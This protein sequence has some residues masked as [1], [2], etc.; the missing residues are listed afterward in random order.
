MAEYE[1][2]SVNISINAETKEA[3]S[4]LNR[5]KKNLNSFSKIKGVDT[6]MLQAYTKAEEKFGHTSFDK[7]AESYGMKFKPL[8]EIR[9]ESVAS[10]SA[11]DKLKKT[12]SGLGISLDKTSKKEGIFLRSLKF[13]LIY[14]TIYSG[15]RAIT[16][17]FKTG[18]ENLYQYSKA[19]NGDFANAMDSMA[20]S[21][22]YFH[23]SVGAAISPLAE[24]FAPVLKSLVD[25]VVEFS[26]Q[27]NQVNAILSGN[28]TWTKAVRVEKEYAEAT[29]DAAEATKNLLAGF[30]ELN[31]IQSLAS[32]SAANTPDYSTMFEEVAV[33]RGDL[34]GWANGIVTGIEKA[35][36]FLGN[37]GIDF[38][39]IYGLALKVGG[40]LLAWKLGSGLLSGVSS[41]IS[42]LSKPIGLV[43][44]VGSLKILTDSLN[45]ILYG[46]ADWRDYVKAAASVALGGI[47]LS[48]LT[49]KGLTFGMGLS[50]AVTSGYLL[51]NGLKMQFDNS[52][53]NDLKG[54]VV[55]AIGAAL[56]GVAIGLL[57]GKGLSLGLP[58]ALTLTSASLLFS[59]I[60]GL[61][62]GASTNDL[63]SAL[64]VAIGGALGGASMLFKAGKG[65]LG[66]TTAIGFSI[67]SATLLFGGIKGLFDESTKNDFISALESSL[68][69]ALGGAAIANIATKAGIPQFS[70]G[71]GLD[72]AS[73][74]ILFTGT[75]LQTAANT[76]KDKLLALI[77]QG[78]G[79]AGGAIRLIG[80]PAGLIASIPLT[81]S[82]NLTM[83][84]IDNGGLSKI[85]SAISDAKKAMTMK[86]GSISEF[87]DSYLGGFTAFFDKLTKKSNLPRLAGYATGGFPT[88]GEIFMAR[89][90]GMTEYV[91]SMGNRA[92][93]ANNDQIVEGIA[94]GVASANSE[95]NA[96]LREQNT[97]LRQLLEKETN[98]TISPSAQLGRVNAKSAQMYKAMTGGY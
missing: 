83:D 89:E 26:N 60:K 14:T 77:L 30:D 54:A 34:S 65:G 69:F 35:R 59:G 24:V 46:D 63:V 41:L 95:Q 29:T 56:G 78:V 23:N 42:S 85:K 87:F 8:S 44:T 10:E 55:S 57:S 97:L 20:T 5:L 49:G 84:F 80:G 50:L 67:A 6:S 98:V 38:Q 74:G 22:Q 90:N 71:L 27:L 7:F 64:E 4:S 79:F 82:F 62:D 72:F 36:E 48:M 3:E 31:V 21:I 40:A 58:L 73:L 19:I 70:L 9:Q 52:E 61:F 53:T 92:A 28:S 94:S 76:T 12:I 88:S 96:L 37:L 86:D 45:E 2:D 39:D 17:A 43:L 13:S 91:G 93:V 25:H 75:Q 66:F 51:Y 16:D 68:G 47:G 81:L 18:T 32:K 33:N 11:L 15:M 1:V